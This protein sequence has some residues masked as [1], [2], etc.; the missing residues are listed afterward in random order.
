MMGL[1]VKC[2]IDGLMPETKEQ[3]DD[4]EKA[5]G[6]KLQLFVGSEHYQEFAE[7]LVKRICLDSKLLRIT[8]TLFF[9]ILKTLREG[10]FYLDTRFKLLFKLK[11]NCFKQN[12]SKRGTLS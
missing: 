4:L 12:T 9:K 5:I 6:D 2:G 8:R 3:F 1:K 7:K 11:N 10:L